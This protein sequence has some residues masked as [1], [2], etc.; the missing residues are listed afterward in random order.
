M[1]TD[2]KSWFLE[3]AK[4]L[5]TVYRDRT[6]LG[7]VLMATQAF[8]YNAV[9]FTYALI[10]TQFLSRAFGQRRVV[11]PAVCGGEFSGTARAR[12]I[13]RQAGAE[14]DDRGDCPGC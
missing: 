14:A 12:E 11:H 9:F 1:R 3:G 8:C 13:I 6:F 10:L 5:M 7:V 2:L 4:T